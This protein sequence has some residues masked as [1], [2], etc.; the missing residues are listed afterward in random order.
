MWLSGRLCGLWPGDPPGDT[1][2]ADWG[3]AA[4]NESLT[5][6]KT[7][8]VWASCLSLRKRWISPPLKA[9]RRRPSKVCLPADPWPQPAESDYIKLYN[10]SHIPKILKRLIQIQLSPARLCQ[11]IVT[12]KFQIFF[13]ENRCKPHNFV[14]VMVN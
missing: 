14:G 1:P 3:N 5:A 12:K 4:V 11:V 9:P 2:W 13:G 8:G 7:V 10:T 6:T